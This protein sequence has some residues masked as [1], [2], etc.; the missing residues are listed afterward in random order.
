MYINITT[1][2]HSNG[3]KAYEFTLIIMCKKK[4]KYNGKFVRKKTNK[5]H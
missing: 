5:I 3:E 1:K 4:I 2:K